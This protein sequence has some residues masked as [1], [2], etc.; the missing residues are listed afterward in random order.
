MNFRSFFKKKPLSV[1]QKWVGT[2]KTNMKQ[3]EP[4]AFAGIASALD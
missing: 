4:Y 1:R 2:E 3:E